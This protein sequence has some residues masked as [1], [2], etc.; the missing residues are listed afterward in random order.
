MP[1]VERASTDAC[2]SVLPGAAVM[3]VV[4]L[5]TS[6][7]AW[8]VESTAQTVSVGEPAVSCGRATLKPCRGEPKTP[9]RSP[10]LLEAVARMGSLPSSLYRIWMDAAPALASKAQPLNELPL[11]ESSEPVAATLVLITREPI[12]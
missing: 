4:A 6:V 7:S 11:K 12:S 2:G 8:G 10:R 3:T 1:A 5:P 9:V